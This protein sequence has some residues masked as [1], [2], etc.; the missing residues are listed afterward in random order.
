MP[1]FNMRTL[2]LFCILLSSAAMA[3]VDTTAKVIYHP[4]PQDSLAKAIEKT[5]MQ[6]RGDG[7]IFHTLPPPANI[8]SAGYAIDASGINKRDA[9]WLK[10]ASVA[11]GAVIWTQNE[12]VGYVVGGAGLSYSLVLD[13]RSA[14]A[15]QEGGNL[16]KSG[17]SINEKY[18][19][20]PDS[21]S[22]A[23]PERMMPQ[24]LRH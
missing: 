17:Y 15:L 21:I 24:R 3:Q 9:L 1:H 8:V 10:L 20:L 6:P 22:D 23:V 12:T 19:L 14:K 13:F 16:L 5:W 4:D 2:L 7:R 11:A 18:E